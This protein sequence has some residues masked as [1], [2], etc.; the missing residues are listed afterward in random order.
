MGA[1]GVL[2]FENDNALDWVWEL[3]DAEDNSL[4]EETLESVAEQEE[5][6]EQCEEALAAAEVVA[7]LLGKPLPELPDGV[8]AFLKR[9]GTRK[10]SPKLVKLAAKVV[11]AIG[12]D[13]DLKS[14]W[15]ESES[16]PTWQKSID[17][18]LRRLG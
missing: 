8:Q 14:R 5:I 10:P 6:F 12:Q 18:L 4:L 17:D 15:D 1:W 13:S 16:A 7:A 11:R 3:D 9:N 2:P